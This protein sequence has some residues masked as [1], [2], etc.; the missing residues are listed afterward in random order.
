MGREIKSRQGIQ[1]RKKYRKLSVHR[2]VRIL[3]T[4][5]V[6]VIHVLSNFFQLFPH[7]LKYL[8]KNI[9]YPI[10]SY[11]GLPDGIFSNQESHFG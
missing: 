5:W 3:M 4:S 8:P 7:Q 10:P 1:R 2:S 6:R 11:L 9:Y